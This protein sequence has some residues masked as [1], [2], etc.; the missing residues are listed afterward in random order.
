MSVM[1]E[2]CPVCE[3]E[4]ENETT[5]CSV[6]GFADELGINR[7]WPIIE[8]AN[9]WLETVVKPCKA[10]WE[11]VKKRETKLLSRSETILK[12]VSPS[13]NAGCFIKFGRYNW[14]M[15]DV[16][17]QNSEKL[18][19]CD[20]AII[21]GYYDKGID[22]TWEN[23]T[24]RSYLNDEFYNSFREDEKKRIVEKTILNSSNLWYDTQGG[25]DTRDKIFLLSLE[26]VDRYFGDSGDY[27]IKK[28]KMYGDDKFIT[29]S[30]GNY[31]SNTYDN[32]RVTNYDNE[33]CWWWLR[34]PGCVSNYVAIVH[35]SG[36]IRVSG[37]DVCFDRG[38]VRP[39]LWLAEDSVVSN[40]IDI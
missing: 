29:D 6:C 17:K 25:K 37:K 18:L 10:V 14:R 13:V 26:E 7:T 2:K 4:C 39:A 1:N 16:D 19:L 21:M 35:I 33:V 12:S 3:T 24:L 22:V 32:D 28:R 40:N 5:M 23:C 11:K 15:L 30:N 20:K 8:D 27:L 36:G 34:S 9:Y 31:L 38:G